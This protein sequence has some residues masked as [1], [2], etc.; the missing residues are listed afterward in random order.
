MIIPFKHASLA[1]VAV[2]TYGL[3]INDAI[4]PSDVDFQRAEFATNVGPTIDNQVTIGPATMRVG[5]D[6][7]EVLTVVGTTSSTGGRAGAD[8]LNC[9]Q[10]ILVK[11]LTA[12]GGRRGRGRCFIPWAVGDTDV[13]EVGALTPSVVTALQTAVNAWLTGVATPAK[14]DAMVVLHGNGNSLPGLPNTVT[15]LQVDPI[16]G[17][18]RRRLGRR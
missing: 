13:N 16:V 1:R 5:Q 18:Q 12:R 11:K 6:G 15:S 7:G 17:S 3:A 10:A 9:G 14:I 2:I 4:V 8:S